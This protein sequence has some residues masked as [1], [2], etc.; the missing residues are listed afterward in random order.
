M[1]QI[2]RALIVDDD[3]LYR[4]ELR[5]VLERSYEVVG[6]TDDRGEALARAAGHEADVIVLGASRRPEGPKARI[7]TDPPLAVLL[8]A[9]SEGGSPPRAREPVAVRAYVRSAS[10]LG[11]LTELLLGLA[12]S[13]PRVA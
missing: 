7:G 3:P 9:D 8:V 12:A 13:G 1:A 2:R 10:E 6:E 11:A 4:S 5:A